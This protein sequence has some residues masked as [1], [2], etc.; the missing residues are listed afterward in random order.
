MKNLLKISALFSLTALL[1]ISCKK[2]ENQ[3]IL[4]GTGTAPV[5]SV[6]SPLSVPSVLLKVNSDN[7]WNTLKWTNPNYSFN[8]GVSSQN[9]TY[10]I[11]FD[12][13]GSNFKSLRLGEIT[14]ANN[15]QAMPTIGEVNK[16]INVTL[17][18][19]QEVP[20]NVEMRIKSTMANGS[21]P[22]YSNVLRTIVTPYLDT[23][24]IMPKDLP[25]PN[26][27]NGDLFLVG[28]ATN[29]G[30]NNPVPTPTQKFSQP[31]VVD[32]PWI[33]TITVP[34]IGGKEYLL[35]PKNG[36]WGNKYAVVDKT[37]SGLKDGGEFDANKND[38]FPGPSVSGDYKIT[39]DF[40]LG[41]FLVK[42]L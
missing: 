11:Q 18:L 28:D 29:G 37:L 20:H 40:Q 32:S 15:L 22:L 4:T 30:W 16:A 41:T 26:G 33:Y 23:K 31:N 7:S 19:K 42:K 1:F 35:L 25:S 36:D 5:L 10:T 34:L 38:N 14:I 6:V 8:T 27:N 39:V 3:V 9:V 17:R 12:T 21:A 24:V 2:E 13:V